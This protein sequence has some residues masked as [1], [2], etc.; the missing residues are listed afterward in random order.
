MPTVRA[1]TNQTF[2]ALRSA[3]LPA[4]LLLVAAAG[5]MA[6]PSHPDAFRLNLKAPMLPAPMGPFTNVPG[7]PVNPKSFYN[8]LLDTP[9]LQA[10]VWE[11]GPGYLAI[12][13]YPRDEVDQVMSGTVIIEDATTH[14]KQTFHKGDFFAMKKGLN[15][16]W[17]MPTRVR[18]LYITNPAVDH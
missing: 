18:T 15:C 2:K 1:M 13:D 12:K 9:R 17:E 6:G 8:V 4:A 16:I 3:A 10:G 14:Q 5:A 11:G 7:K